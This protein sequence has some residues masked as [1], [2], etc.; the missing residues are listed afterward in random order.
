MKKLNMVRRA[1]CGS[2]M[3]TCYLMPCKRS[4][5]HFKRLFASQDIS[6][7]RR[8]GF[9]LLE[10]CQLH[11]IHSAQSYIRIDHKQKSAPTTKRSANDKTFKM[12]VR[13]PV[14]H[15]EIFCIIPPICIRLL[16]FSSVLNIISVLVLNMI[17][18]QRVS[19]LVLEECFSC[20]PLQ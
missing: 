17:I 2:S 15:S 1:L 7:D 18:E 14:E 8:P 16:K 13:K 6:I 3:L 20:C 5:S 19:R 12:L 4:E 11:F 10:D 9:Q